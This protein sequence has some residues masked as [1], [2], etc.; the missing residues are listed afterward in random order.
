MAGEIDSSVFTELKNQLDVLIDKRAKKKTSMHIAEVTDVGDDGVIWVQ[1]PGNETPTPVV[2]SGVD[3]KIGDQV[4]VEI[5]NGVAKVTENLTDPSAGIQVV[6]EGQELFNDSLQKMERVIVADRVETTKLLAQKASIDELEAVE[7]QIQEAS[8][9]VAYVGELTADEVTAAD[10]VAANAYTSK[11]TADN[12]DAD[13]FQAYMGYITNLKAK[14]EDAYSI[15][16]AIGE[17]EQ[18]HANYAALDASN[19]KELHS[20]NAWIN[21]LLVDTGLIAHEGT[22]FTLDAIEVNA[23]NITTGTLDVERLVVT[24]QEGHKHMLTV[25]PNYDENDPTSQP[26]TQVKLDGD[27]IEDLT[28]TADKIVA[29]SITAEKIT[30]ENIV[31]EGGWINLRNGT[32]SYGDIQA[33]DGIS[34][35][36]QHLSIRAS[37]ITFNITDPTTQEPVSTD[38]SS[39]ISDALAAIDDNA[40]ALSANTDAIAQLQDDTAEVQEAILA[41]NDSLETLNAE[42]FAKMPSYFQ[43]TETVID[44]VTRPLLVLGGGS[45]NELRAELTND[46][47]AFVYQ[48]AI[49]GN[50]Y[51]PA[52]ISTDSL[53]IQKAEVVGDLFFGGWVWQERGNGHMT[54]RKAR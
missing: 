41:A 35:D 54:L 46:R 40:D 11:L 34:W 12:I 7:A 38:L 23:T 3:T 20:E 16:A 1:I 53:M 28:I 42:V 5:S 45:E 27:V 33:N 14:Y 47:L 50:T 26:F 10:L 19:I 32:F 8:I 24:D 4:R 37:D 48:D 30:T 13:N 49:T 15:T 2:W 6:I 18:L 21:T 36:G 9:A 25:N 43:M 39:A 22:I 29:G 44:G 51:T 17:V 52:Y 31:G